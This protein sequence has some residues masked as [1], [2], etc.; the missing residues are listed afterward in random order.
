MT[1]LTAIVRN[2]QLALPTPLD[3]P[4]GT[5]VE[6]RVP[7]A[8]DGPMTAEEIARTLAAMDKVEP[9]EFTEEERAALRADR[10]AQKRWELDSF[11]ERADKLRGTWE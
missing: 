8:D 5:V 4:D 7:D 1:T 11:N 2:G 9:L 6:V 3:L 10:Q